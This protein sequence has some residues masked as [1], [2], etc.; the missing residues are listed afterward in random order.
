MNH[1]D[2]LAYYKMREEQER[3]TAAQALCRQA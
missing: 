2:S 3:Q 1:R